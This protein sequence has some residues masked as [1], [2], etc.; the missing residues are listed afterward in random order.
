MAGGRGSRLA[1]EEEKPLVRVDGKPMISYVLDALLHSGCFNTIVVAL[2]KNTPRTKMY[3]MDEYT[4]DHAYHS[5]V[6]EGYY[7]CRLRLVDTPAHGYVVD[8]N[9]LIL[10]VEK[11]YDRYESERYNLLIAPVDL[12]LLDEYVVRNI[13]ETACNGRYSSAWIAVVTSRIFLDSLGISNTN[14][15]NTN[16]SVF[17]YT[18]ISMVN[19]KGIGGIPAV[20][21]E[22]HLVLD[23]VRV[24]VNVNTLEDLKVAESMLR[25]KRLK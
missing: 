17:C 6:I 18:G 14:C 1:V 3:L 16:G 19:T 13:V 25:Y 8:L 24:A 22:D 5:K 2:S 11:D 4:A 21:D 23:D 20:V 12:P 15:F 10:E 7:N 9:S